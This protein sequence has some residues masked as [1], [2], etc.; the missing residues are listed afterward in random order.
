MV[1]AFLL[2][3]AVMAGA[4]SVVALAYVQQSDKV[5]ALESENDRILTEHK[6]IGQAFA[7]QTKRL[8]Q[9][10]K[11]LDKA[12]RSSFGQGYLAGQA[13]LRMPAVLRPLARQSASGM[14]VPRDIPSQ[15][16]PTRP[17]LTAGVDGYS[18]RW[19][20]V[21]LFASRSDALSVWTRQALAG[22][23]R[24][25]RIGRYRVRRLIGP[26]G[27]IYA[28]PHNGSTYAV[29]A[30]PRLEGPARSLIAATE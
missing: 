13:A 8:A 1:A 27:V 10:S 24:T 2:V 23:V 22:P 28:W 3:V 18:I 29:I 26:S 12:L 19:R 21:A 5:E 16:G 9:Q 14:A 30:L 25:M 15:L 4:L 20:D 6:T 17:R 11:K 7:Q